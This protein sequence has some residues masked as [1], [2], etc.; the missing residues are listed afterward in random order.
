MVAEEAQCG[1]LGLVEEFGSAASMVTLWSPRR[2]VM[3]IRHSL[4]GSP[5]CFSDCG[6]GDE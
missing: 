2:A 6:R 1:A 4:S 5:G 3:R